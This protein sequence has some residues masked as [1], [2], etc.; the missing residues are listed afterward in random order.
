MNQV[1]IQVD[2]FLLRLSHQIKLQVQRIKWESAVSP[3]LEEMISSSIFDITCTAATVAG[4][5]TTFAW[6]VQTIQPGDMPQNLPTDLLVIDAGIPDQM[7][8]QRGL[9]IMEHAAKFTLQRL[10]GYEY[11]LP[12]KF[13]RD[14]AFR[15]VNDRLCPVV[16]AATNNRKAYQAANQGTSVAEDQRF[17]DLVLLETNLKGARTILVEAYVLYTV[18]KLRK[19]VDIRLR[20]AG[21]KPDDRDTRSR[22]FLSFAKIQK[23]QQDRY[24][25][26][27]GGLHSVSLCILLRCFTSTRHTC[28]YTLLKECPTRVFKC[29]TIHLYT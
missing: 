22:L 14:S 18:C 19:T 9:H 27:H 25:Y 4:L 1:C 10:C 16:D 28:K 24:K 29:G 8:V 11:P 17:R 2:A 6:Q 3:S 26:N 20:L 5:L 15:D 12:D 13:D 7:E 23:V 21:F